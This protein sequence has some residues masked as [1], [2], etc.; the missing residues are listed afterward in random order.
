MTQRISL[1]SRRPDL[2]PDAFSLHWRTTHAEV[3]KGMPG[4][5]YYVQNHRLASAGRLDGFDLA[6]VV[7]LGFAAPEFASMKTSAPE[8]Y[9]ALLADEAKFIDGV[10]GIQVESYLVSAAGE[11]ATIWVCGLELGAVS[12]LALEWRQQAT[13][14]ICRRH[15]AIA[16]MVREGMKSLAPAPDALLRLSFTSIDAAR[17]A[18]ERVISRMDRAHSQVLL[19]QTRRI[20]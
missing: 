9:P 18:F 10:T 16:P 11:A 4:I 13:L 2:D 1:I 12:E 8:L 7:E 6:G 5:I 3:I 14:S 17:E 15:F 20:I 19:A